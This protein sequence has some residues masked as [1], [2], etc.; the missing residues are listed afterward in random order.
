MRGLEDRDD[1]YKTML[2][3][4]LQVTDG[5]GLIQGKVEGPNCNIV[6]F[7]FSSTHM[8]AKYSNSG[9]LIVPAIS[10]P[11]IYNSVYLDKPRCK[12]KL[13]F[14]TEIGTWVFVSEV[15]STSDIS[16]QGVNDPSKG[17]IGGLTN[18]A[19]YSFGVRLAK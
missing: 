15:K 1:E 13:L 8:Q 19:L 9:G 16:T 5:S 4:K 11:S 14:S 7:L 3:E 2:N 10:L 17:L 12:M 6:C 18:E